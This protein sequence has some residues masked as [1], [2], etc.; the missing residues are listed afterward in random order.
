MLIPIH[1]EMTRKALDKIFDPGVLD[2]V[3]RANKKQDA[4]KGQMG[5]S[6]YHFDNNK[7][8]E[9]LKYLQEQ[10]DSVFLSLHRKELGLAWVAFGRLLHTAQD[11][12]AHTNY[13]SL[14]LDQFEEGAWPSV[15]E[16]DPLDERTLSHSRLRSG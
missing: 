16:I 3:I 6:E 15:D 2:H 5:H 9:S 12:Y 1:A 11:F 8:S 10:R 14:W 7:I 13:V 4:I